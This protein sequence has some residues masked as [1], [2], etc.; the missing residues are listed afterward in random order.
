MR[1]S[2]A[3]LKAA[4][5]AQAEVLTDELLHWNENTP[6]PTLTQIEDVILT[7]RQ[8]LREHMAQT[9][10]ANQEATR[11]IPGLSCPKC[12]QERHYKERK[13][14]GLQSRVGSLSIERGYYYCR[15]CRVGFFPPR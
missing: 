13:A 8:R 5:M 3:E 15:P 6:P 9:V 14:R 10:I 12:G 7:L 1:R 2:R 4:L 11:P